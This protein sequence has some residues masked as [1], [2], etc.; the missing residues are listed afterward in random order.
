MPLTARRIHQLRRRL[1]AP[2]RRPRTVLE[3]DLSRVLTGRRVSDVSVLR[4][5]RVVEEILAQAKVSRADLVVMGSHGAG[6][7]VIRQGGW[8]VLSVPSSGRMAGR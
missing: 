5:G 8:P 7:H 6:G 3:V 4:D 2:Q 1:R